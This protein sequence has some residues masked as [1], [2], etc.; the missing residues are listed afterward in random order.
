[1]CLKLVDTFLLFNILVNVSNVG[2]EAPLPEFMIIFR[3]LRHVK[4]TK[5]SILLI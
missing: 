4:S 1:M 2:P 5:L 3:G